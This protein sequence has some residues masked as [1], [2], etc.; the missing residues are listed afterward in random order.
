MSTE[1]ALASILIEKLHTDTLLLPTLPE[2]A[3]RVRNIADCPEVS[4]AAMAEVISLDPALATRVIR[5]ANSAFLGRAIK[6]ATLNQAV[7]RIGLS[8][9]KTIATAMA[10][11]QLFIS[12]SSHIQSMLDKA[13]RD[14]VQVTSIAVACLSYYRMQQ[15]QCRLSLD[16]M[17]LAALLHHIGLLPILAEA[18]RHQDVFGHP[19]FLKHLMLK[20]SPHIGLAIMKA[21]GFDDTYQGVITGW[22]QAT[23]SA[24][25]DYIDFVR[26]ATIAQGGY[27]RPELQHKLLEHYIQQGI[28]PDADFMQEPAIATVYQ[29]VR[30]IFS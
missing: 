6:V 16:V 19:G 17:T 21:W 23:I 18:E 11:E 9:I 22:Q 7:T 13:W 24:Q 28:L 8:Q 10:M 5:V 4:L 27:P 14:T 30:S 3:L 1:H 29:D 15:K 20:L 12:Q 26:I 2:I 25:P